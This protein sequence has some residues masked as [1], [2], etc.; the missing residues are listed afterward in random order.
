MSSRLYIEM[1]SEGEICRASD[2]AREWLDEER[3]AALAAFIG[4]MA[5]GE[6]DRSVFD[7][8]GEPVQIVP[9]EGDDGP[10]FLVAAGSSTTVERAFAA[11]LTDRQLEVAEL[12]AEGATVDEIGESLDIASNTVK[13]HLKDIYDELGI[14]SRVELARMMMS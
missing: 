10:G 14:G 5:D 1:T 2:E 6:P 13:H 9:V 12:A 11:A 7:L 8:D 3:E 4:Q